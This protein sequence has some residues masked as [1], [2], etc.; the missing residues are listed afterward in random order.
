MTLPASETGRTATMEHREVLDPQH[1]RWMQD[2]V[3]CEPKDI[4]GLLPYHPGTALVY[5]LRAGRKEY[6]G[7]DSEEAA[8]IEFGKAIRHLQFEIERL[9]QRV[10]R[11]NTAERTSAADIGD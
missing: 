6:S 5:I 3:G 4:A 9:R 10:S 7:K 11:K 8:I 1:Y 2:A